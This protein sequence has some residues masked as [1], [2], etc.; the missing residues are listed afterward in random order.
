MPSNP[1]RNRLR[2]LLRA[3][4]AGLAVAIVVVL[5]CPQIIRKPFEQFVLSRAERIIQDERAEWDNRWFGTTLLQYPNDLVTYQEILWKQR[6]DV[7]IESGTF[8]GGLTL[9]FSSI[10]ELVKPEAKIITVDIDG[11]YWNEAV[12]QFNDEWNLTG[13]ITFI[14]GDSVSDET[15]DAIA[16]G[17][18]EGA[19]VL[20]LLDSLHTKEH[21]L[22]ELRRYWKFVTPGSYLIV[23]DT[24][25]DG[26]FRVGY[27]PGP[28]AAVR[29]FLAENNEFEIDESFNRYSLATAIHDGVLRRVP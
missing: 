23:N 19:R 29:E 27:G 17:I 13:R 26:N 6:P 9:Y 10:L 25:L 1:P 11:S 14:Q 2:I 21:V 18:P 15:I 20:V 5:L 24:H 16:A 3:A 12:K 22:N 4:M 8:R 7:I 28:M